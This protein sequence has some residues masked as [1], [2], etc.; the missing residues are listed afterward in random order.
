MN[1]PGLTAWIATF[2]RPR[3]SGCDAAREVI[4]SKDA[5]ITRLFGLLERVVLVPA[6]PRRQQQAAPLSAIPDE[7]R[8]PPEREGRDDHERP[9]D[10]VV[11]AGREI[12]QRAVRVPTAAA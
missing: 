4:R 1:W 10:P 2:R 3:C 12:G 7:P 9:E 6:V 11:A 5:E 8:K